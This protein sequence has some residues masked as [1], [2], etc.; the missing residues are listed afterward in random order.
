MQDIL[1]EAGESTQTARIIEVSTDR[2][3]AEHA[4]LRSLRRAAHQRI[5]AEAPIQQRQQPLP[6]VP[7]ADDQQS[8]HAA[9]LE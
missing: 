6:D 9:I 8:S 5:D 7:A 2:F 4:Q 3:H 1:P